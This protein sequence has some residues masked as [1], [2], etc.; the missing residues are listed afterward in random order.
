MNQ[1]KKIADLLKAPTSHLLRS[2]MQLDARGLSIGNLQLC[3][4]TEARENLN[5]T[6]NKKAANLREMERLL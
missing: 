6:V 3:A 5:F 1:Q 4:E 2:D